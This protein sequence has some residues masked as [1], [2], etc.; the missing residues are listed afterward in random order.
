V[1]LR[2]LRGGVV[3]FDNRKEMS[4]GWACAN[5]GKPFRISNP[6]H[7]PNDVIWVCNADFDTFK[8]RQTRLHH[9]RRDDYFRTPLGQI[10]ADLGLRAEG[11]YAMETCQKLA[12]VAHRAFTLAVTLYG[13]NN[14]PLAPREE[15]LAEDIRKSLPAMRGLS[16]CDY[17]RTPLASAY[18]SYSSPNWSDKREAQGELV[19]VMLRANRM[20]YAKR[21]LSLPM[22][23]EA[24]HYIPDPPA[25]IGIDAWLDPKK[26]SLVEVQVMQHDEIGELISFGSQIGK[27]AGIRTWVSQP[28]LR[29]LIQ[30]TEVNV[31]SGFLC[32]AS[33]LMPASYQ[34][35]AAMTSDPMVEMSYSA[36]LVAESHWH[37][38]ANPA[39]SRSRRDVETFPINAWQRAYDRASCFDKALAAHQAGFI[40]KGYGNGSLNVRVHRTQLHELLT[41]AAREGFAY[42]AFPTI[43]REHDAELPELLEG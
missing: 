8:L 42:P 19:T 22:P 15:T 25:S 14:L 30:H 43:F 32:V 18:Q 34:L 41:F 20:E 27:R 13:K 12:G 23:D 4:A 7:L 21:L 37:A 28:E 9:L 3:L 29:M 39:W 11:E 26:P 10:A 17:L 33:R 5:G 31:R 38:M 35:P 16:D 40:V 1:P 24:W 6:A 2:A 36:G